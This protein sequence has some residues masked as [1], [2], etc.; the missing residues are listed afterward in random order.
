MPTDGVLPKTMKIIFTITDVITSLIINRVNAL[1]YYRG[2][3][4]RIGLTVGGVMQE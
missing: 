4:R 1:L 2:Y 3:E